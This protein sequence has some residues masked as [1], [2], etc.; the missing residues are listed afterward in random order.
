[1][2]SQN[3]YSVGSKWDV[4]L[5]V[6]VEQLQADLEKI[7]TLDVSNEGLFE[8]ITEIFNKTFNTLRLTAQSLFSSDKVNGKSLM[9]DTARLNRLDKTKLSRNYAAMLDLDVDIPPGMAADYGTYIHQSFEVSKSLKD[10]ISQVAQLRIDIGRVISTD[11]GLTDS[12]LF[13]DMNY[14]RQ[15]DLINKELKTLSTMK[16]PN[17]FNAVAKYGDVFNSGVDIY[18]I[19]KLAEDNSDLINSIDRKKLLNEVD[20]AVQYVR[21]LSEMVKDGYSKPMIAKIANATTKIA[22]IVEAF[23]VCVYNAEI[24]TVALNSAIGTAEE[25]LKSK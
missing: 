15:A 22:E 18:A 3:K 5:M 4:P 17:D 16:K 14:I 9:L 10:V 2:F 21:D 25:F 19:V 13:S 6:S 1:M 20:T 11:K 24:I 7:K 12:T 8:S 23:S